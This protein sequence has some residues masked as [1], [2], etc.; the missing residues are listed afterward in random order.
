MTKTT[1]SL[2]GFSKVNVARA[3]R[4]VL[5]A[6]EGG[7]VASLNPADWSYTLT[8]DENNARLYTSMTQAL[9]VGF[10]LGF[11]S[12]MIARP[13]AGDQLDLDL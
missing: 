1:S 6:P 7:F 5:I 8:S 12:T 2:F 4:Y 10:C 11:D 3:T 13:F 9:C